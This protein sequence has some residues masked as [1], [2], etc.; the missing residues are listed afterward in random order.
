VTDGEISVRRRPDWVSR[1]V[2]GIY[3]SREPLYELVEIPE[4]FGPVELTVDREKIQQFAYI[5]D[6]HNAWHFYRSPFGPPVA[7]AAVLAN[8][9]LQLFTLT[10]DPSRVVGLHTEEMLWFESPVFA[11]EQVRLEGSYVEKFHRR[12]QGYVVMEA[13]ARGSDGRV[14]VRHRGWEIMRTVPGDIAGRESATPTAR[15]VE[16]KFRSDVGFAQR[17]DGHTP[18][19]T[20]LQPLHYHVTPAQVSVFSRAGEYVRNIHNDMEKSREAG[21]DRPLI[22]GQHVVCLF[23]RLLT[24]AFGAAWFTTGWLHVKFLKPIFVGEVIT[25]QGSVVGSA[26][27]RGSAGEVEVEVWARNAHNEMAVAGWA[28]ARPQPFD[29]RPDFD[30]R[31]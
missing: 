20:P 6:D 7:H 3:G 18:T 5:T 27:D 11:D 30:D 19:G 31:R 10:Y 22:Q 1:N 29:T 23:S 26:A 17:V 14:L 4:K 15:R 8:D 9:L 16:G 24:R 28:R 12:G 2:L 13:T 21:L 25:V